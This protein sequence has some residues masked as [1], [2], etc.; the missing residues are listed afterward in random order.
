M[1]A[2]SRDLQPS[3]RSTVPQPVADRMHDSHE[4]FWPIRRVISLCRVYPASVDGWTLKVRS[5]ID[6]KACRHGADV[7][8]EEPRP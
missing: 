1:G 8:A 2:P 5:R 3:M 6:L 7:S 4:V